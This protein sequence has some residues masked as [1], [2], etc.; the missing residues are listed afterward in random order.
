[1][2]STYR[3][4]DMTRGRNAWLSPAVLIVALSPAVLQTS[5]SLSCNSGD[6]TLAELAIVVGGEDQI[7][8]QPG[9]RSYEA[10]VPAGSDVASIRARPIDALAKVWVNRYSDTDHDDCSLSSLSS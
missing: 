7:A 5:K 3:R 8:F 4:G 10:W 2:I 6:T 9:V 1:M